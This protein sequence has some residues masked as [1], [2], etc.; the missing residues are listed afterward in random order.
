MSKMS[1]RS[2]YFQTSNYEAL[3]TKSQ[4]KLD[5]PVFIQKA[6]LKRVP[7]LLLDI[8]SGTGKILAL[9]SNERNYCVGLDINPK[10]L[11]QSK[12]K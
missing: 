2:K 5:L 1:D 6:V 12:K 8:G 7:G 4:K 10:M 3:W 11:F 9:L